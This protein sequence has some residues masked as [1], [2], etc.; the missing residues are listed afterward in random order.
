MATPEFVKLV[1]DFTADLFRTFP[2]YE[3]KQRNGELHMG[4][5]ACIQYQVEHNEQA[6]AEQAEET[7]ESEEAE[8]APEIQDLYQEISV[9]LPKHFFDII[10]RN[11]SV[12]FGT[13]TEEDAGEAPDTSEEAHEADNA[14]HEFILPSIDL[15]YLWKQEL[16]DKTREVLWNY[17]SLFMFSVFGNTDA[18]T[19][20]DTAKLFEAIDETSLKDK[21]QET[22]EQMQG[23][24]DIS[25]DLSNN[26][27]AEDIPNV[28]EMHQ[29][30]E[31]IMGG[32]LGALAKEIAEET[33]EELGMDFEDV[34][35]MEDVFKRI[36][37]NPGKL[38]SMMKNIS[39]KLDTK[40]KKG[41]FKE[42][43]LMEEATA[44]MENM[45]SMPGMKHFH[46]MMEKMGGGGMPN[47]GAMNTALR[48]TK[49]RERMKTKL[50]ERRATHFQ[51]MEESQRGQS[52]QSQKK[53]TVGEGASA[54]RS[55]RGDTAHKVNDFH[56]DAKKQLAKKPRKKRGKRKK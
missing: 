49:Q 26:F 32:K 11:E 40:M 14:P 1:S 6:Q 51:T 19:F 17:L 29:H 48:Q 8:F 39:G 53:Y 2:E 31:S 27:T 3:E 42:S 4:Y 36:I 10:Y 7:G 18:S 13:S 45:K 5:I 9:R 55:V 41:D 24:F 15:S 16:T 44:M 21:L 12:L 50:E 25:G 54:Y 33:A 35:S 28:D 37:K 52:S 23:M 30:V 34:T 20:G 46:K 47:M 22:I 38:M 43:E 56:E